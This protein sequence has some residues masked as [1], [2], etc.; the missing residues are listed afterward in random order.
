[1]EI[2][3]SF[4]FSFSSFFFLADDHFSLLNSVSR[5]GYRDMMHIKQAR[6]RMGW[7][8]WQGRGEN[9]SG[10]FCFFLGFGFFSSAS[11]I[12]FAAA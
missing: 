8:G 3:H 5:H 2:S 7:A 12:H 9:G 1:M 4:F 10:C 11:S 6:E